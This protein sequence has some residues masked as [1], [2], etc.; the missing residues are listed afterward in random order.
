M[1]KGGHGRRV[2]ITGIGMISP[3]GLDVESN[4]EALLA[5]TPGGGTSTGGPA[6]RS[7]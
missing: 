1:D 3:V 7:G 4:W 6:G 5:G 2:A